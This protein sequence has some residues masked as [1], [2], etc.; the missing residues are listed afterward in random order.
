M[1]F[2]NTWTERVRTFIK[3]GV[4]TKIRNKFSNEI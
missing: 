1:F 4:N 3:C 2:E